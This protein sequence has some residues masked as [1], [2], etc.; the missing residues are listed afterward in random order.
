MDSVRILMGICCSTG[1]AFAS[2]AWSAGGVLLNCKTDK[3][4]IIVDEGPSGVVR[5]RSWNKPRAITEK[6]DV[7]VASKSA[8]SVEGT[9]PCRHQ[10]MSFRLGKY[11]YQIDDLKGCS[12]GEPPK[13]AVAQLFVNTDC[14]DSICSKTLADMYCYK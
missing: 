4:Q 3:H 13:G 7:Q 2:S 1:F 11:E 10:V 5:Y 6:P 8:V 14:V 12:E 9:G